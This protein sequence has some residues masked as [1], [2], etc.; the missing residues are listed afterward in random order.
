MDPIL[1]DVL[2]KTGFAGLC[3]WLIFD[4]R[5][6]AHKREQQLNSALREAQEQ[7]VHSSEQ[8]TN[9]LFEVAKATHRLADVLQEKPCLMGEKEVGRVLRHVVLSGGKPNG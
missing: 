2:T 8:G 4:T 9:A 5:K 7:I 6:E 1:I 3:I